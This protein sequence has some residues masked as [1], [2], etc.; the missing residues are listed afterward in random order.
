M[1]IVKPFS[2]PLELTQK[3]SSKLALPS[4]RSSVTYTRTQFIYKDINTYI[5]KT[6]YTY[7]Q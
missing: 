6:M 2:N 7:I 3:V 4:R 1:Q 5:N